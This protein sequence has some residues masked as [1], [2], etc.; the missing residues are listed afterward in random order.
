MLFPAKTGKAQRLVVVMH[1][2]GSNPENWEAHA[3]Q[4][5][6]AMPDA[7]VI[8]LRGPLKTAPVKGEPQ[9]Y[10]WVPHEGPV[11]AQA[12]AYL[13]IIFNY[14]PVVDDLND[15]LDRQLAKR[16]LSDEHLGILGNSM[17]AIA[18]L[19]T[20]LHRDK[21]VGGV[22][23]HSGAL[24]PLTKGKTKPDV[25]VIMGGKDEIFCKPEEPAK[26]GLLARAFNKAARRFNI[27]HKDT[28]KRLTKKGI[29][30]EEKFYPDLAHETSTQTI[31]DSIAFLNKKL[32]RK[33]HPQI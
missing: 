27:Q 7:D 26:K 23:A 29:N 12:K 16:G 13:S 32:Q 28:L 10:T 30:F 33:N 1:G 20:T 2:H 14:L 5:H 19:Q 24:L 25:L 22:V 31:D 17:G 18:A 15:Y 6:D 3:K 8:N 11:L 21:P 4:V 9:G